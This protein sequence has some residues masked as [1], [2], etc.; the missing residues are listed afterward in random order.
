M[1]IAYLHD[2]FFRIGF[3]KYQST[4]EMSYADLTSKFKKCKSSQCPANQ[5]EIR[6]SKCAHKLVPNN[7]TFLNDLVTPHAKSVRYLDLFGQKNLTVQEF[8]N[9]HDFHF[10]SVQVRRFTSR[11]MRTTSMVLNSHLW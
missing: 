5:Q 11:V 10:H 3:T 8:V 7:A 6:C 9:P 1:R 4:R 2:F